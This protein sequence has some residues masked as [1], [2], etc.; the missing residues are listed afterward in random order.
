MLIQRNVS[1]EDNAVDWEYITDRYL[2]VVTAVNVE[3]A[4]SDSC[5][6]LLLQR[7]G[8]SGRRL[9]PDLKSLSI[10]LY[11]SRHDSLASTLD[12]LTGPSVTQVTLERIFDTNSN[13]RLRATLQYFSTATPHIQR[14]TLGRV[15][16][17]YY[18]DPDFNPFQF[19]Q[20]VSVY[21]LSIEGWHRLTTCSA[22]EEV[23]LTVDARTYN[24]K[25]PIRLRPPRLTITSF[26]SLRKLSLKSPHLVIRILTQ[27]SMPS[28]QFLTIDIMTYQ[29][30]ALVGFPQR[31]L[32]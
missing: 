20:Y 22:V 19:L 9:C 28:L 30:S 1:S 15:P 16:V 12:L 26:R 5:I 2:R 13:K 17:S 8:G 32:Y 27:T 24:R 11:T 4:L 21:K 31:A 6:E 3:S 29:T 23:R 14:L 18:C 25:V 7:L 10:T